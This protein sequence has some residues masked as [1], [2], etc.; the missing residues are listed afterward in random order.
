MKEDEKENSRHDLEDDLA[1]EH[2]EHDKNKKKMF[3]YETGKFRTPYREKIKV[4]SNNN[5]DRSEKCLD[6]LSTLKKSQYEGEG[7]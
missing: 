1:Q 5:K 3:E 2:V 6:S 7:S 4:I